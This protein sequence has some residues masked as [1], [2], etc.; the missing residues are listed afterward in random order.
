MRLAS[1]T[2]FADYDPADLGNLPPGEQYR[3]LSLIV[4]MAA[5]ADPE[6]LDAIEG[7]GAA[8]GTILG[9][10]DYRTPLFRIVDQETMLAGAA[11]LLR[12]AQTGA[13]DIQR[14]L[15]AIESANPVLI[16]ML[17]FNALKEDAIVIR[18][19]IADSIDFSGLAGEA[20]AQQQLFDY[21]ARTL[22]IRNVMEYEAFEAELDR[23]TA[24]AIASVSG[25]Q[26]AYQRMFD[27]EVDTKAFDRHFD[28]A[29]YIFNRSE[30]FNERAGKLT[31]E[32]MQSVILAEG[33]P[34]KN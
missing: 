21:R 26:D 18:N 9:P 2:A 23:L 24:D 29:N 13:A 27:E 6:L 5:G 20:P 25:K 7:Q 33:Q 31:E 17:D 1:A 3:Q 10:D 34:D 8:P 12:Y 32:I 19:A 4:L 15:K 14:R 11:Y 30:K 22:R 28:A 16:S